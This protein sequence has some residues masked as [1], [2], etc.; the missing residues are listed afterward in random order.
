MPK[1]RK[2]PMILLVII[3]ILYIFLKFSQRPKHK[4]HESF[5]FNKTLKSTSNEY[6][7]HSDCYCQK[8]IIHI[9]NIDNEYYKIIV[10]NY[11]EL[12]YHT[13]NITKK[14]FESLALTCNLYNVLR[15]GP[16][17]KIL[18]YSINQLDQFEYNQFLNR[19]G[20]R[21]QFVKLNYKNWRIRVYHNIFLDK[22]TI[23]EKQCL[24][25]TNGDLYDNVDFCNIAQ[26]PQGVFDTWDA[27][28]VLPEMWKWFPLGDD[29]VER[30]APRN[31]G[32]CLLKREVD[33]VNEWVKSR[34]TFHFMRDHPSQDKVIQEGQ[35]GVYT[36]LD[37]S[38][39]RYL[40][41]LATDEHVADFYGTL[42][43]LSE[44][45]LRD[46]V[47]PLSK[48]ENTFSHDSYYCDKYNAMSFPSRRISN[49][50]VGS[51]HCCDGILNENLNNEQSHVCPEA[52]RPL[53]YQGEWIF[54]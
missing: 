30:V 23:C 39:S 35:W 48:V 18:S 54:C 26:M 33:A 29:F 5:I 37:R 21:L 49:C 7:L 52:C 42:N 13:Y 47:W 45:L 51:T 27:E 12:F 1:N 43:G 50:Y 41:S 14:K 10:R 19:L 8:E 44:N 34:K 36:R 6:I 25:D 16:N 4:L 17:Q 3:I 31:T 40:F 9:K 22:N 15:R 46:Y 38:I 28:F 11:N 53:S 32:T 24:K 20:D 2:K